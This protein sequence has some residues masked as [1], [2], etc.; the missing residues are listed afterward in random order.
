MSCG[1]GCRQGSDLAWLWLWLWSAAVVLIRPLACEPPYV[2]GAALKRP[3]KKK[4]EEEEERGAAAAP[5]VAKLDWW[6]W[7]LGSHWDED[8]IPGLAQWVRDPALTQL[9][10][11]S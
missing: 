7:H 2:A 4:K 1:V 6:W 9:Q 5:T 11:R 10:L 8:S 3:K